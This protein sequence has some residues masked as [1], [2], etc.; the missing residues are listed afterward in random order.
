MQGGLGPIV[1]SENDDVV[2]S[3]LHASAYRISYHT[4][5]G[6][7]LVES[8]STLAAGETTRISMPPAATGP[9]YAVVTTPR[10][11]I[12]LPFMVRR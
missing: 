4:V 7:T 11:T 1:W 8:S 12:A 5:D 9:V 2:I 6:R 3:A 10:G